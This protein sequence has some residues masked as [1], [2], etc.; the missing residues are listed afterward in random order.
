MKLFGKEID[1]KIN[2]EEVFVGA[3]IQFP[4]YH[5]AGWWVI[6]MM[7]LSAVLWELGGSGAKIVRRLGCP[8]VSGIALLASG[9][10]LAALLGTLGAFGACTLGYGED[11]IL[12]KWFPENDFMIRLITYMLYW[13]SFGIALSVCKLLQLS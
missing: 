11:S 10:A 4:F 9:N 1:T 8:L 6:A 3:C 5:I 12:Y 13:M 7:A 2:W